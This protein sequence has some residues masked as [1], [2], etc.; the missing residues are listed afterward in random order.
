VSVPDVASF[1]LAQARQVVEAAG[2]RIGDVDTVSSSAEAGVIITTRPP[3]GASRPPGTK[4]D[5]VVSRGPPDTRVPDVVGLKQEEARE[6]LEAA[7]LRVGT[8]TTRTGTS[9]DVGVVLDQRPAGGVL[10]PRQGRINLVV[11]N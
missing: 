7:G 1:E 11:G 3:I 8:I 4:V 5:L 9:R 2:L 10:S 6:R